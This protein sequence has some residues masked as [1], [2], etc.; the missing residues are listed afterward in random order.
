MIMTAY[1]AIRH[2]AQTIQPYSP[3][4]SHVYPQ[5]FLGPGVCS[6]STPNG[7]SIGS[8]VWPTHRP[9]TQCI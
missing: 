4:G 9:C 6:P 7:I 1:I 5:Q 2:S 8:L 3:S